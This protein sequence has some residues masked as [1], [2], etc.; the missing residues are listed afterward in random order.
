MPDGR[1]RQQDS[2][3]QVTTVSGLPLFHIDK[4]PVTGSWEPRLI[5]CQIFCDHAVMNN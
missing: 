4:H 3:T 5:P 2:C 1:A